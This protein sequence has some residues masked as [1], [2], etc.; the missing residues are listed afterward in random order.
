MKILY[1]VQGTGNGHLSRARDIYPELKKYAEVDILVSGYQVDISVP[2]PVKYR[3]NGLSFIFGKHGAVSLWETLKKMNLVKL[4]R[5]I[6]QLPVEEYDLVISDFEPV[7]AWACKLKKIPC[8]ALSHQSAVIHPDAPKPDI[9]GW[10]GRFVLRCYAPFSEHYGFHFQSYS[11]EI[12]TPVIRKEI[13]ALTPVDNGHYT[14][15]LPAYDDTALIKFLNRFKHIQW[16][17]FSKHNTEAF[18]FEHISIRPV[19]NEAF[20]NSLATCSG[21]LLGAGFEGPAE[22]LYLKKKLMVVP[23]KR[24]YEQQC[25]AAALS[26]LGVPVISSLSAKNLKAFYA[27]LENGQVINISFSKETASVAVSRLI[28]DYINGTAEIL[29]HYN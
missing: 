26:G 7:S 22:A 1:A 23:M 28:E 16:E 27:W 29:Q 3:L 2:Y 9:K 6:A 19:N 10:F 8:I 4:V 5:D 24:Q 18:S 17:V 14:V 21:A 25:N 12:F 15:Y 13:Q 11:P 20:L